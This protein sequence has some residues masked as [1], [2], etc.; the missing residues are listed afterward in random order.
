MSYQRLDNFQ[1]SLSTEEIQKM[2][3]NIMSTIGELNV[4]KRLIH[5]HDYNNLVNHLDYSLNIFN[6]MLM[7]KK[8]E[9][10]NPYQKCNYNPYQTNQTVLHNTDGTTT[11][12]V[13]ERDIK[14]T[15]E[16]EKQ[17]ESNVINPPVYTL[18]PQNIW[19]INKIKNINI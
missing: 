8:L 14:M 6:N 11:T 13:D 2:R 1:T 12:I 10:K 9:K 5:S 7:A 15:N 19:N 16:W 3:Q 18:P 4:K 17:F